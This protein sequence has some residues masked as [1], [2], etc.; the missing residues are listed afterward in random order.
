MNAIRRKLDGKSQTFK[1]GDQNIVIGIFVHVDN[2][3]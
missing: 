1:D 2:P 3:C